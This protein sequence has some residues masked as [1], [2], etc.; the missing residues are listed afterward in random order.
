MNNPSKGNN[1]AAWRSH[2]LL[3]GLLLLFIAGIYGI[4]ALY[5]LGRSSDYRT[6]TLPTGQTPN[7]L[8]E[9]PGTTFKIE[10][11]FRQSFEYPIYNLLAVDRNKLLINRPDASFSGL[12]LSLLSID[13]KELQDIAS[14]VEYGITLSPD[15]Q[16]LIYGKFGSS[17]N[18]MTMHAYQLDTGEEAPFNGSTLILVSFIDDHSFVGLDSEHLNL[19]VSHDGS[20]Q[21]LYSYDEM[22]ELIAKAS[23]AEQTS[24]VIFFSFYQ[25]SSDKQS[26]Y[27]LAQ[28]K[29]GYGLYRF[30]LQKR[31]DIVEIVTAE[32]IQQFVEISNG[33]FIIQGTVD[34]K[35][36][37]YM[38][39][40]PAKSFTLLAE[41]P[42]WNMVLDDDLTRLAYFSVQDNQNN[43]LH[44]ALLE[45]GK[46]LSDTV[47][48]RNIDNLQL[49]KWLGN[50]LF[51]TGG[52]M[53]KSELYRF[54][55]NAW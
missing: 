11:V 55:L 54:T 15:K 33:K 44:V 9:I 52:D 5:E 8:A 47:I 25:L 46:L 17:W 43:E 7:S 45:N 31:E 42:I 40:S 4:S 2:L 39:D 48:Y 29:E 30:G 22:T 18:E 3:A 24:D 14:N 1:G 51:L 27:F 21:T 41:G 50:D 13:E 37:I 12:K 10:S 6:V 32:D 26:I 20:Q 53:E 36:G 16:Q 28:I 38:Y 19:I 23:G 49:M 34:G 35:A